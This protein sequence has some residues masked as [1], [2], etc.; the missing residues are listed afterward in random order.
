MRGA[1]RL[2]DPGVIGQ[3]R[4]TWRPLR[5]PRVGGLKY[6]VSALLA[7]YVISPVDPIPDFLIGLGQLDNVGVAVAGI[8][9]CVNLTP[10]LTRA[11]VVAKH[12]RDLGIGRTV[13]PHRGDPFDAR[14]TVR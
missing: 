1:G 12:S 6:L 8:L 4:L 10:R 14:F 2:T 7:L 3:I 13:S 11:E 5:D 9:L